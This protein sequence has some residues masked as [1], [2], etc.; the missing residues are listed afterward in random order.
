MFSAGC[1][2]FKGWLEDENQQVAS[3]APLR[4]RV[5]V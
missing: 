5:R 1:V 4:V 3:E 2:F